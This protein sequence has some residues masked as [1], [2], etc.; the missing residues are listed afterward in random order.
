[1]TQTAAAQLRRL[2]HLI[3]RLADGEMHTIAEVARM[4]EADSATIVKD[5]ESLSFRFDDPGGFVE[6]VQIFLEADRM[7][8]RSNHFLRPMR[9]TSAELCAL[10]LGLAMLRS[11]RPAEEHATIDRARD[12]L[13]KAIVKLPALDS[14]SVTRHVAI[15][16]AGS[17]HLTTL[18][19][20][21]RTGQKV[22]LRYRK[23]GSA[24]VSER[25]T[26][27]FAIVAASGAWY[28][29][30]HCQSSEGMRIFRLDRIESAEQLDEKFTI[31]ADFSVREMLESGRAWMGQP[32]SRLRVRYS[33]TIARWIAEREGRSL[34]ADGSVTIDHP[35]A[36]ADWAVR[37]V[38]QYGPEAEV[39]EPQSVRDRLVERLAACC[40]E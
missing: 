25:V 4:T 28:V 6:G 23:G 35:L 37:H 9:L 3:P 34:D 32:S 31:P 11:E 19:A 20:A 5:L 2:L 17:E 8:L 15:S 12:R 24:D 7:S 27:P 36:D 18:R 14:P 10:E 33:P 21:Y 16:G 22:R 38:L 40:S 29:I 1:M 26:C 39:L 30:A 13:A